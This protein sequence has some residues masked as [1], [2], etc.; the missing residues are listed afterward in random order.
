MDVHISLRGISNG[1]YIVTETVVS[2]HS[3]SSFDAWVSMGAPDQLTANEQKTLAARSVPA[4]S[5]Y[6]SSAKNGVL[7]IDALLDMLEIRLIRIS[8]N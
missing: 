8:Q 1:D 4:I 2:R 5:K 3:G 7:E 6:R